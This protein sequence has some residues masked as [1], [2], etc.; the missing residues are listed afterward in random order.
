DIV[1]ETGDEARFLDALRGLIREP[2]A[3][4]TAASLLRLFEQGRLDKAR[5]PAEIA[6]NIQLLT[7]NLRNRTFGRERLLAAKEYAVPQLLEQ[8]MADRDPALR[9]EIY[10]LLI[11]M[12]EQAVVPLS[13][14]LLEVDQRAQETIASILG[15]IQIP[16][17]IPFLAEV[18]Q[19]TDSETV[20]AACKDALERIRGGGRAV[21]AAD[22]YRGLGEVYYDEQQ[23]V[24]SFPG[25]P[26]QLLWEYVP[27]TGLLMRPI[28]TNVYHEAMAM[29]LAERSL[30]LRADP[31]RASIALWVASNLRREL[32]QRPGYQNPA[33]PEDRRDAMY[34]AVASGADIAQSVLARALRPSFPEPQL[35]RRAIAALQQTAGGESLW[36]GSDGR[37][38]PL[39]TALTYPTRRIQYES[40][41]A[42]AAAQ[43]TRPFDGSQRVAPILAGAVVGAGEQYALII[44]GDSE[45]H[46]ALRDII[47][48]AG[49]T[50]GPFAQSFSDVEQQLSTWPSVDLVVM[51]QPRA[52]AIQTVQR[53]RNIDQLVASPILVLAGNDDYRD[54]ERDLEDDHALAVRLIGID[55]RMMRQAVTDLATR[56]YGG[57]I[58]EAEAR[59]Y[60]ALS[61]DLLR[62]LAVSGNSVIRVG[63][64][65]GQLVAALR[66]NA[67][68]HGLKIA[69]VLSWIGEPE[70]QQQILDAALGASGEERLAYLATASAS[71][72][73]FGDMLSDRQRLEVMRIA[74]ASD[75]AEATAAAG[76]LGALN[77]QSNDLA[78][79][80]LGHEE[81]GL[82][83][84]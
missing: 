84:R 7:G 52:A 48:G 63:D 18:A 6:K 36:T 45:V 19:T 16:T 83:S 30:T 1:T 75:D 76:L 49:Y 11:D 2:E 9:T 68:G 56:T 71:A 82:S 41:L 10:T 47:E 17:A 69:D 54:L 33:Y 35:A 53:A 42:L 28:E 55:A 59:A 34:Y 4:P 73:R 43:P 78:P 12:A 38:Q 22:A 80:I 50:V 5:D 46:R 27:A 23:S 81:R 72:R 3:E 70:A 61:L 64:V 39:L 51:H 20:A 13:V 8:L 37:P 65:T 40:A 57:P 15:R 79:L 60:A 26:F 24:T 32:E 77:I 62:D 21:D 74:R 58:T 25:E 31:N 66:A 44:T 67:G 29:R 14:A